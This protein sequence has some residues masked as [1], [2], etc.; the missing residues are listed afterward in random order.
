VLSALLLFAFGLAPRAEIAGIDPAEAVRQGVQKTVDGSAAL[1]QAA[2]LV[3]QG[4]LAEAE[5]QARIALSDPGTRAVANSVLGTIRF[6]QNRV[7][8]SV[9]YLEEAIRLEPRLLGAHLTLAQAYTAQGDA[10]RALA[11]FDH[12]LELD[13]SNVTARLALARAA[14]ESGNYSRSLELARPVL[15]AFKES[16]DG[17]LILATDFLKTDNRA[18]VANLVKDWDRLRSV[19]QSWSITFG[20]LLAKEGAIAEAVEILERAKQ[21]GPPSY[22][23][24]FNLGSVYVLNNQ[25]SRALDAYDAALSLKP[26]AVP[27]LRSAAAIAERQGELER[28][29]SYWIR[30]KKAEPENPEILLGFGRVCLRMDLL[31]DAEP[32]LTQAASLKPD[33]AAYQYTLAAAKVGKH[34]FDSAQALLER[35]IEKRPA[36]AQMQYALGA[37]LYVQGHLE[38]STT[39]LR[40]SIRLQP[41]QL[42]S[43]YYLALI[44]RD[45]GDEAQAIE[46]LE[47]LLGR[48]PEHGPSCEV[49]GGLLMAARRYPEAEQQLRKAVRL[50]P[51]SVKANYQLG[52]LLSRMGRKEDADKQFELAKGLRT[53]QEASSR[54]QLRLLDPDQVLD[55]EQ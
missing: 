15:P 54:L 27:A 21:T 17:L 50:D 51:A 49:L 52:L 32:A 4:K 2:A 22:N 40:E 29:L 28:A 46:A 11:L 20:L 23:L 6:Q 9:R 18:E 13:P 37:V 34:Q 33:E 44:A 5:E 10:K 43:H 45:Q 36:D 16:P 25:P 8:D 7:G 1:Q 19:P 30:A 14:T 26:D 55:R 53:K 38:E 39:H 24:A 47:K 31:D 42:T 48:Y 3:Q 35:L 12:V 41:G